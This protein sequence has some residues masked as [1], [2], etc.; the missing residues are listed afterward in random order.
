MVAKHFEGAGVPVLSCTLS[1]VA[2]H[3]HTDTYI[4]IHVYV[5]V[6]LYIIIIVP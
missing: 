2:S 5:Y 4:D 1:Y 3:T 6:Y